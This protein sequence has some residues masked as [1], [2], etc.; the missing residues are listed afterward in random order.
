MP[1]GVEGKIAWQ[2]VN[3]L[4]QL[5]NNFFKAAVAEPFKRS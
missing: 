3:L 4:A 1:T 5:L 2:A